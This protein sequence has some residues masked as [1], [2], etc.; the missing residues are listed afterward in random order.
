V[1]RGQDIEKAIKSALATYLGSEVLTMSGV[2][3]ITKQLNAIDPSGMLAKSFQ[4]S[5]VGATKGFVTGADVFDSAKIGFIQGGTSGAADAI[6]AQFG[7]TFS[8]LSKS[9]QTAIKSLITGSISGKPFDQNL[10]DSIIG[11]VNSEIKSNKATNTATTNK[12]ADAGIGTA[13]STVLA[14]SGFD[15]DDMAYLKNGTKPDADTARALIAIGINPETGK[16]LAGDYTAGEGDLVA[17]PG[18]SSKKTTQVQYDASGKPTTISFIDLNGVTQNLPVSLDKQGNMTYQENG[19]TISLVTDASGKPI[20]MPF[21]DDSGKLT[22]LNVKQD[23]AT[24][25]IYFD[26]NGVPTIVPPDQMISV[27][28]RKY[29]D[30]FLKASDEFYGGI[31]KQATDLNAKLTEVLQRE[32]LLPGATSVD[33]VT[34]G[35]KINSFSDFI[36]NLK[37]VNPAAARSAMSGDFADMAGIVEAAKTD[38]SLQS[39]V[40]WCWCCNN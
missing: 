18:G 37:T 16:F 28:A 25:K 38:P 27:L 5:V 40:D 3:D 6:L 9:Q 32:G 12:L 4:G 29:P 30:Q 1:L 35:K 23:A 21:I 17:G 14:L 26:L 36:D 10:M 15:A 19:K 39:L 13:E 31:G 33:T 20:T 7:D 22:Q 11:M 24:G 34:T 2:A 8:G